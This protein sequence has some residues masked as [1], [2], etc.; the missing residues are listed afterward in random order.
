MGAGYKK[1]ELKG[2][3]RWSQEDAAFF[4]KTSIIKCFLTSGK[5]G[6][7]I[8]KKVTNEEFLELINGFEKTNIITTNHAFFRLSSKQRKLF[9]EETIKE[10]IL[11][12]TPVF[13]GIQENGCYSAYYKVKNVLYR[14]IL[15]HEID[16]IRVVSFWIPNHQ[17]LPRL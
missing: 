5:V 12:E 9:K 13:A 6:I 14:L 11:N 1:I 10:L 8:V 17:Q 4:K 2:A 15:S 3:E 16:K 7:R